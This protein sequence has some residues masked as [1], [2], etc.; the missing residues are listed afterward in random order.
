MKDPDWDLSDE[1]WQFLAALEALGQAVHIGLVGELVPL[2]PGPFIE[3]I[4]FAGDGGWIEQT[5]PDVY[6]LSPDLPAA[7]RRRLSR[8]NTPNRL[9]DLLQRLDRLDLKG[10]LGP[11]SLSRLMS[12]TGEDY[13]AAVLENDLAQEA[14][15]AGE[16]ESA[17]LH[18]DAAV[19]CLSRLQGRPEA[20]ALLVSAALELSDLQLRLGQR[21]S[22]VP[23]L[24]KK[25]KTAAD[26]L[27][28]RRSRALIDL[29]LGRFSY[30]TDNLSEALASLVS[31][32]DEVDELGDEDIVGRSAEFAGLYY[33][34]QGMYKDAIKYLDRAMLATEDREEGLVNFFLPYTFGYCTAFLG[35]FNRALGVLDYNLRRYEQRSDP[36]LAAYFRSALGMVLLL[37][38]RKRDALPHLVQARDES[39]RHQN[40]PSLLAA[41]IGLAHYHFLEGNLAQSARM[42]GEGLS[43][44]AGA[45]YQVRHYIF[46]FLLD[47]FH[48]FHRSGL[49]PLA[50]DYRFDREMQKTLDG[51]NIHLRGVAYR[52]RAMEALDLAE[53]PERV[54]PDLEASERYLK[55]SGDPMELAKT[56]AQA[57]RLHLI[58]GN[59]P[60][61]ARLAREA[62]RVLSVYEG[63]FYPG[64]LA[65]LLTAGPGPAKADDFQTD[66]VERFMDMLEEF[67]PSANLDELLAR[68]VAVSTKF[69]RAER[70]GLFWFQDT[71]SG[72]GPELRAAY[73]LSSDEVRGQGFRPNLSLV[74]Q[75]FRMN[76]PL[77]A[78]AGLSDGKAAPGVRAALCLPFEIQDQVRGVLYHD[79]AYTDECFD[80]LDKD[81]LRKVTRH[82]STYIDRIWEY[83][84]LVE[85]K[86][87]QYTEQTVRAER[88]EGQDIIAQSPIMTQLLTQADQAADS[89]A[90]VLI[91]GETGVGKELLARRLHRLSPRA[92]GPFIVVDLTAVPEGLVES[93]L[94]GHEKGAFTGAYRQK[95]GRLELAHRGTLFIDEV[96]EVPLYM[97][98]KLLRALQDRSFVRIGG[99]R[100]QV[101]D[102][103]L[104]AATNRDLKAEVERGRFREDLYYRLNV[105]PL[106]IPPLRQR[107]PDVIV[108]A[109]H[110]LRYFNRKHHRPE[111]TVPP[112][113]QVKLTDYRW[114]GNVRELQNVIEHA[115]L[116]ATTDR[117]EL[118]ITPD[119]KPGFNHPFLDLPT[120]DDLQ[121][122]Y[123]R[124]VLEKTEGRIAGPDGAA[125]LLGMKRTTFY[126]R[127]KKLGGI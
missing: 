101:S 17:M 93:E 73:N 119:S 123:I 57:A 33:F 82:M 107:G 32:L 53:D 58:E 43:E 48:A 112:D 37:M 55:R 90:S 59:R 96:G 115:V 65:P 14:L 84:R 8:L 52:I 126:S 74:F 86:A 78:K 102:F 105:I 47:H 83:S 103:R 127:M 9:S 77:V 27:G 1:Q 13:R 54:R 4:R 72:L 10:R 39:R 46:P 2:P 111:L 88:P 45:N 22:Q 95:P 3:L 49:Q 106:H 61:A 11:E 70:G 79:T 75:S 98:S 38:G 99:T 91:L 7:V 108:L 51:P 64:E 12:L 20:E 94:F 124:F 125:E 67:I 117:L 104:V 16:L 97:Q 28:D 122:R 26:R 89:E 29:H 87:R 113:E 56:R 21:V 15:K 34:L 24:L 63:V 6:R 100:T 35:Q 19:S 76:Q 121:R 114:P 42:M 50:P 31:G 109:R 30:V 66:I 85:K 110:F 92:Q 118:R 23:G 40:H 5:D 18:L 60:E 68:V 81:M 25:A 69:Y 62:W 120:M 41:Q 44:A 80:F 36:G 71:R 116:M